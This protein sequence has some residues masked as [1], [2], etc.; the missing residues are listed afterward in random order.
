M[1]HEHTA[2]DEV[3][4]HSPKNGTCRSLRDEDSL[5]VCGG[6]NTSTI[7]RDNTM[8]SVIDKW[9]PEADVPTH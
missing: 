6:R 2:V 1:I 3:A 9:F 8:H 5:D 4:L 7:W